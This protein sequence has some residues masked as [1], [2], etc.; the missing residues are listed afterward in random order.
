MGWREALE[1]IGMTCGA[2]FLISWGTAWLLDWL[3]RR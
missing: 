3:T 1:L 2:A